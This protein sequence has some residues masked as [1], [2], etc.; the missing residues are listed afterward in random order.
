[1][2]LS[3]SI[4]S[5]DLKITAMRALD[6]GA[7]TGEIARKY[8]LS[9]KLLERWRGEWR[10]RGEAAFPGIG[11]RG[12]GLPAL[13]DGRRIADLERKIGQ[14]TMENDFLKK[15]LQHFRDHHPP[16]VVNGADVCLKKSVKPPRKGKR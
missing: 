2:D 3:R 12:G 16:A 9:P 11:H 5:R 8:Q 13:D 7:L 15:A 14:L 6:A 10:A 4:Y 1:M